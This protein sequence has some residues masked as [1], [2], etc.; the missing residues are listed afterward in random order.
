MRD[1]YPT[2]SLTWVSDQAE[3]V[4]SNPVHT[5]WAGLDSAPKKKKKKKGVGRVWALGPAGFG[6]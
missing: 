1:C 5:G 6:L 4:E 2:E 3:L